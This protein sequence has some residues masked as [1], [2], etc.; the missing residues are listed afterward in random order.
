MPRL[1]KRSTV[2]YAALFLF[3]IYLLSNI[4]ISESSS[5]CQPFGR[6][7]LNFPG[8]VV[9][10]NLYAHRG[11]Y[12]TVSD[13][14]AMRRVAEAA[15]SGGNPQFR[16]LN[17]VHAAQEFGSS[18]IVLPGT[19]IIFNDP[20]GPDGYMIYPA[21]FIGEAFLGA[22]KA[23]ASAPAAT[24]LNGW[25]ELHNVTQNGLREMTS[26]IPL[27]A[28]YLFPKCGRAGTWQD[29][30][31]KNAWFLTHASPYA[32]IE[33]GGSWMAR[34]QSGDAFLFERAVIVDRMAAH[35]YK[36]EVDEVGKMS[37]AIARSPIPHED[38][39]ASL[40]ES[41]FESMGIQVDGAEKPVILYLDH[42]IEGRRLLKTHHD[43]LIRAL[44]E[45]TD[46]AEVHVADIRKMSAREK[47]KLFS[48][49][50]VL[51]SVFNDDSLN[52][53]WMP[54]TNRT[55]VIELY[56]PGSYVPDWHLVA[57]MIGHRYYPVHYDEIA[58]SRPR[59]RVETSGMNGNKL[60]VD[61]DFVV[62]LIRMILT[63]P[64]AEALARYIASNTN[65]SLQ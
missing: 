16:V 25:M 34:A 59:S 46:I 32:A 6:S 18:G 48:R 28:R 55:T 47:L 27:P 51:I 24:S 54:P 63:E 2:A 42:Q 13:D 26:D 9:F 43:N 5:E 45:L 62:D 22:W 52:Q 40:R 44:S 49:A 19:T 3:A 7:W 20:P 35:S 12:V 15:V 58:L 29:A 37:A 36:G 14:T 64:D 38:M 23:I 10:D 4:F 11:R 31:G 56:D 60:I 50:T 53:I 8:F 65:I 17:G 39:M 57:N 33:E 21:N 30:E 41:F 1:K 61:G